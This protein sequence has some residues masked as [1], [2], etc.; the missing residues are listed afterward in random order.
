MSLRELMEQE[1]Y[2]EAK[3]FEYVDND[4]KT[5]PINKYFGSATVLHFF[6]MNDGGLKIKLFVY[7]SMPIGWKNIIGAMT[8]PRGF[9]WI[10]NGK[11]I[12]NVGYEKALL[13]L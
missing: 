8:A 5:L 6:M 3:Y 2:K 9:Q 4:D 13:R 11:S 12:F 10:S 1:I 7:N